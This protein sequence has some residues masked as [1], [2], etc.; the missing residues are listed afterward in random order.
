MGRARGSFLA[1]DLPNKHGMV[2]VVAG[3]KIVNQLPP[4]RN[5][6]P[7]RPIGEDL[8]L[9][10]AAFLSPDTFRTPQIDSPV[11]TFEIRHDL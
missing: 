8:D 6:L 5:W 9:A 4:V 2:P 1:P 10:H 3:R 7:F 11:K